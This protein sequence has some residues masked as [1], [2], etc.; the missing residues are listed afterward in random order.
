MQTQSEL[1]FLSTTEL[2]GLMQ[3]GDLS[4]VEL[5]E[6]C[7]ER[8]ERLDGR[9][10]AFVLV[11]AEEARAQARESE[12]RLR[13]GE[14]RPLEGLPVPIKDNVALAGARMTLSSRMAPAFDMPVDAEL[15][16]RLRRAGAVFP[17]KTNLP[18][19]GTIPTTEGEVHGPAHNPW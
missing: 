16:A 14:A 5:L 18:E 9:L 4:P 8:I 12:A 1:A 7:L 6:H 11:L 3:R 17:G 10:N 13:R 19:F 2:S 15:V